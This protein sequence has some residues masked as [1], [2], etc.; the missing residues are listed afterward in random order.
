L[1]K[2]I[3]G[4]RGGNEFSANSLRDVHEISS[5][6]FSA[7]FN[8]VLSVFLVRWILNWNFPIGISGIEDECIAFDAQLSA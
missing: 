4:L 7:V 6:L 5:D 2:Y 1:K 8:G 3:T